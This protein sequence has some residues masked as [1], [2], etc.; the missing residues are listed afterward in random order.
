MHHLSA[1]AQAEFLA[2]PDLVGLNGLNAKTE[3]AGD[4]LVAVTP[5][6]ESQDF[7]FAFAQFGRQAASPAG[8][9]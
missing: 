6:Q 2:N 5:G 3:V 1:A 7:P 9:S 8:W 4:F